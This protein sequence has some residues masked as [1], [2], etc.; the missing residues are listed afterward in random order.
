ML[1]VALR[2]LFTRKLRSVLS[3][4]AIVLGVSMISGTYVLTD[5]INNSFNNLFQ[6]IYEGTERRRLAPLHYLEP[7]ADSTRV[8]GIRAGEGD[9]GSGR[10]GGRR[11]RSGLRLDHR[12]GGRDRGHS[13]SAQPRLQRQ[14]ED[15]AVQHAHARLRLLASGERG[16]HR[17]VGGG[18]GRFRSRRH[19]RRPRTRSGREDAPLGN[20]PFRLV[21]RHS[22]RDPG[23][24]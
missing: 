22:R 2:G 5:T 3:A 24:V 1:H 11:R 23:G 6:E 19:D 9:V 18:Q 15:P 17:P 4:I 7:G 20:R 14:S 13:W 12:R 21:E 8:P 16:R 10:G